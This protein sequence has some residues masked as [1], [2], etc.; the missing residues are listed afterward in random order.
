MSA[1]GCS[2]NPTTGKADGGPATKPCSCGQVG[3][4]ALGS[5]QTAM[6][7]NPDCL[8]IAYHASRPPAEQIAHLFG[9]RQ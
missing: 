5:I 3:R 8:V 9:A 1:I 4:Y 6:C 7:A 2:I